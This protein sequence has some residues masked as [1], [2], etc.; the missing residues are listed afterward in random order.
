MSI[1]EL[2]HTDCDVYQAAL[3]DEP[4]GEYGC[5]AG[6]AGDIASGD[7]D[8]SDYHRV[9]AEGV[10]DDFCSTCGGSLDD[11]EGWDGY[12]GNCADRVVNEEEGS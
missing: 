5:S 3:A 12:C 4:F 6:C 1:Q 2:H 9:T 8:L 7:A 10:D 11:G